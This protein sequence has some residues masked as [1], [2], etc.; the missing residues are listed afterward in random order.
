MSIAISLPGNQQLLLPVSDADAMYE[1]LR[2]THL[3]GGWNLVNEK[4]DLLRLRL[5]QAEA[6]LRGL[7][8]REGRGPERAEQ[9]SLGPAKTRARQFAGEIRIADEAWSA[10]SIRFAPEVGASLQLAEQVGRKIALR[11]LDDS[12]A[13]IVE[14]SHRYLT[15]FPAK[16]FD[17]DDLVFPGS[18]RLRTATESHSSS[19]RGGVA[20][21]RRNADALR[22][23]EATSTADDLL[24]ALATAL[25][26]LGGL[27]VF[28]I[29]ATSAVRDTIARSVKLAAERNRLAAG[30]PVLYRMSFP[31]SKNGKPSEP[32][33]D[34]ELLGALKSVLSTT[35]YAQRAVRPGVKSLVW[36]TWSVK[37]ERGPAA[38][39]A[40]SLRNR[41]MKG[42][43]A[44]L[45]DPSYGPWAFQQVMADAA[46]DIAGPGP[47]SSSQAVQDV[48]Q[49]IDPSLG[50]G[51]A[52]AT[53]TM[54][55]MLL[56][57]LVAPPIAI[58]ADVVLAVEGILEVVASF[59][60]D[61]SAFLCALN[62]ADSLGVAPS[63]LRAALQ[64]AGEVAGGLP[65][66]G[67]IV[68]AVSFLAP[69]AGAVVP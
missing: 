10:A 40:E 54:G 36:S 53:G 33:T 45:L 52:E 7:A 22:S 27:V 14:E 23:L 8:W 49:A 66:G 37:H 51:F 65:G 57:H 21:L 24:R 43:I 11:R 44:S 35:W 62:P 26:A 46:A 3:L 42:G 29:T 55:A 4:A 64:C 32:L 6:G 68:G 5:G 58:V 16:I 28:T 67:K 19:E 20:E 39:V 47:N 25:S 56:L 63:V 38:G 48:Y 12:A 13:Q 31:A 50:Q 18:T 9:E 34:T 1:V 17:A 41:G 69:L 59:L 30:H 61:R 15:G 2:G 60:R